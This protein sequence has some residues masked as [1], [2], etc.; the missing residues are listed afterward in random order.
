ML[1]LSRLIQLNE[2]RVRDFYLATSYNP[3]FPVTFNDFDSVY[4]MVRDSNLFKWVPSVV[5]GL[6][7]ERMNLEVEN[8]SKNYERRL[9]VQQVDRQK[10]QLAAEEEK[11]PK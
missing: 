7:E 6:C 2:N 5:G 3:I 1:F 11:D 4:P 9:S 10:Q 8:E